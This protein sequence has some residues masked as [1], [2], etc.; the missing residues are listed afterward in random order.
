MKNEI[1]R[2][3]TSLTIMAI[4]FAGGM[5]IGVPSF[6]PGATADLSSTSGML[7]VSTT[8]LQGVA[9]L[10]IVVNDPDNSDTTGDVSALSASVGGTSY[11]LTQATNGKWYAYV[12]DLSQSKK[13]DANSGHGMEFGVLCSSGL[14][15][16]ASTTSL[17]IASGGA[18]VWATATLSSDGSARALATTTV[19]GGCVD[20]DGA[21]TLTD[22]TAGSTAREDLTAAVLQGA[23]AL[24]DPDSDAANLGQRGHG[25][26]SSGYGSWPYIIAVDLNDDNVVEYGSD[27]INVV[28]GN[29]DSETSIDLSNRNPASSAQVHLTLADPALNIDPTTADIW[30][31]DLDDNSGGASA[32]TVIFANNATSSS[33]NTAF[34]ATDLGALGCVSNCALSSDAESVFGAGAGTVSAV[35]MTE[36][37]ANT[38]VFESFDINGAAQFVTTA[39]AAADTVIVFSYGGNSVDMIITYNDATISMDAG[40]DWSPGQ[41][42]TISVNDPDANRNPTSAETLSVGDETAVIP[43][44]KMGTGGLTLAEGINLTSALA[45]P[46]AADVVVGDD[47]SG[48]AS[49]STQ[50][51][52]TTDNSER[53]RI[54]HTA[55]KGSMGTA[56]STWINVTTGHTLADLTALAGTVVLSYDVSAPAALVSSTDINVW[57]INNGDNSTDSVIDSIDA[58]TSGNVVAGVVDL[59]GS[60]GYGNLISRD[61]TVSSDWNSATTPV[62]GTGLITVAFQLTHA[63]GSDMSSSADYAIYADF[64]NFDQNNGSL[65]HNC[66]YRLEAV[67]TGDNTGIFEGTV[68]YINLNNSTTGGSVRVNTLVT[69][70]TLKAS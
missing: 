52:N 36:S 43:T 34:N 18:D 60:S 51:Y 49:Y 45:G 46:V 16:D 29:T 63:V 42:A 23:P 62:L 53:L 3:L 6:M 65:T 54:L 13:M 66:M 21:G 10:E 5:A 37:G 56:T 48:A 68:E 32:T 8:T 9:I 20:I 55:E 57:V 41:S 40:G 38:G 59:D 31:F 70:I 33:T 61:I 4:M 17:L 25:L 27:A 1:G 39:Q 11:D 44:I 58:Q 69:T 2:K 7:S 47:D 26:N 24:S 19:A 67:E 12:V 30:T 64:C 28:Y 22:A 14:G 50:I 35:D 15:V